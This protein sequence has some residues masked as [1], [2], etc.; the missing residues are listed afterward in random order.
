[1]ISRGTSLFV[2][3]EIKILFFLHE[4]SLNR[5]FILISAEVE[6]SMK[7]YPGKLLLKSRFEDPGIFFYP[8]DANINLSD[9]WLLIP[10]K[11]KTYDICIKIMIQVLPIDI[12]KN[13]IIT[14][15]VV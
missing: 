3:I 4:L 6:C 12:E 15:Y 5:R 10:G 1:V 2:Q 8:I 11:T 9:N 13:L 14:K 7:N